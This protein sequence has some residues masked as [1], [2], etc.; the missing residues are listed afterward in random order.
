VPVPTLTPNAEAINAAPA[1]R[2]IMN[3]DA[4]LTKKEQLGELVKR[5][6]ARSGEINIIANALDELL[7][8]PTH[9]LRHPRY[10]WP[11]QADSHNTYTYTMFLRYL[12]TNIDKLSGVAVS[13]SHATNRDQTLHKKLGAYLISNPS[14]L[15]K[16]DKA[17]GTIDG[18]E[19]AYFERLGGVIYL[20]TDVVDGNNAIAT[21]YDPFYYNDNVPAQAAREYE[22]LDALFKQ[23]GG[24]ADKAKYIRNMEAYF[25]TRA[26][27]ATSHGKDALK[28]PYKSELEKFKAGLLNNEPTT[29]NMLR[30]ARGATS[31]FLWNQAQDGWTRSA[32]EALRFVTDK[33][34]EELPEY[35]NQ[36][37]NKAK[38]DYAN[39]T[40]YIKRQT[41]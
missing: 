32:I 16:H 35:D 39:S 29:M 15:T 31:G 11:I 4:F 14:A 33:L 22:Q 23:N 21:T 8:D 7:N 12:A 20:C 6:N 5:F 27:S 28:D 2:I 1:Q 25:N 30:V 36:V 24:D 41:L 37:F 3:V 17:K 26:G 40:T 18:I 19:L 38:S 10:V 34:H 13:D 9:P